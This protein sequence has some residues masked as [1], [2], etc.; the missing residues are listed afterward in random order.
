MEGG[1]EASSA[2]GQFFRLVDEDPFTGNLKFINISKVSLDLC[3]SNLLVASRAS[4]P[5]W[6]LGGLTLTGEAL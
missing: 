3:N 6:G 1:L 4:G 2:I 5:G